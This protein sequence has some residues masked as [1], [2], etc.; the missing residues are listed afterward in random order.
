M[1]DLTVPEAI[2]L[3]ILGSLI[4]PDRQVS[5]AA[6]DIVAS[7]IGT[8]TPFEGVDENSKQKIIGLLNACSG[9]DGQSDLLRHAGTFLPDCD[10]SLL[11]EFTFIL[12]VCFVFSKIGPQND[13]ERYGRA[14]DLAAYLNLRM[15]AKT[16]M[17]TLLSPGC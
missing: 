16:L 6:Y 8:L 14:S 17:H 15:S 12:G 3:L 9:P 4:G 11:A 7:G 2:F 5:S 10:D 13:D 1:D